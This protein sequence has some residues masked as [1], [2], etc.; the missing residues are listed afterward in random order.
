[1][2]SPAPSTLL[3]LPPSFA[4][5]V[6]VFYVI[7]NF[8]F[9]A[10]RCSSVSCSSEL[11]SLLN[12][13]NLTA[14][15]I[16]LCEPLVISPPPLVLAASFGAQTV[17]LPSP[18]PAGSD[19]PIL[20]ASLTAAASAGADL[21]LLLLVSPLASDFV[22]GPVN[23]PPPPCWYS[24]S[25]Q[26]AS[27]SNIIVSNSSTWL[28]PSFATHRAT[29]VLYDS[30][31]PFAAL[32]LSSPLVSRLAVITL[33]IKPCLFA[34]VL[35]QSFCVVPYVTQP[36]AASI[37]ASRDT[38]FAYA[39]STQS[40]VSLMTI[41]TPFMCVA[42]S[43]PLPQPYWLSVGPDLSRA[44]TSA[45]ALFPP[46]QFPTRLQ[47]RAAVAATEAAAAQVVALGARIDCSVWRMLLSQ[48]SAAYVD[49]STG[50]E[51]ACPAM[52]P[53]MMPGL[54][55]MLTAAE[56]RLIIPFIATSGTSGFYVS[57]SFLRSLSSQLFSFRTLNGTAVKDDTVQFS[58][59]GERVEV[60]AQVL[61]AHRNVGEVIP[62]CAVIWTAAMSRSVNTSAFNAAFARLHCV[63]VLVRPCMVC[64]RRS[65]S[66][67]A[68]TM[69]PPVAPQ[70]L[71]A[72]NLNTVRSLHPPP[73]GFTL[74]PPALFRP[75]RA[76]PLLPE[77]QRAHVFNMEEGHVLQTGI[78]HT[79]GRG[80]SLAAIAARLHSTFPLLAAW[81][82]GLPLNASEAGAGGADDELV[83]GAL[84]CVQPVSSGGIAAP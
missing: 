45:A 29:A 22:I 11:Q 42:Y 40:N 30:S 12:S 56:C 21:R 64:G 36:A 48:S 75:Q 74:S 38:R 24:S 51:S 35:N 58:A 79:I 63:V 26:F 60:Q 2:R 69:S 27:H 81:N 9:N 54:Q 83:V 59:T 80:D 6:R 3:L 4:L 31:S 73:P 32:L 20:T 67:T 68:M 76:S 19:T 10:Q 65:I 39:F 70:L 44:Q 33:T 82:P 84:L 72:L 62:L 41:S 53:S 55:L 47:Q 34:S 15:A 7:A 50:S 17:V 66:Y 5:C 57:I 78:A 18:V 23:Q 28:S 16:D 14:T 25:V 1:M 77:L 43:L 61:L 46:A 13:H 8:S 49:G 71:M 37:N 52:P